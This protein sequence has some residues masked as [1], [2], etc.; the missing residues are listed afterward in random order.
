MT[1]SLQPYCSGRGCGIKLKCCR[2]NDN[3]D[4]MND[5]H[6]P[7]APYNGATNSCEFFVGDVTESFLE[8]LKL[9]RNARA[10]NDTNMES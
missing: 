10:K 7:Y 8:Q 5:L 3:I 9:T 2:Y 6:F 1:A 4:V